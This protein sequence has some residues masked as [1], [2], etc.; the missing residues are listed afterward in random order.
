VGG[1]FYAVFYPAVFI[2]RSTLLEA[3][4]AT[5]T[6]VA[7]LLLTRAPI[8]GAIAPRV[9]LVAGALLGVSAGIKIWG[10]VVVAAV[11]AWTWIAHGVGR[12]LLLLAGAGIGATMICLPF[13]AAAPGTMWRM[14]VVDQLGRPRSTVGLG[15]RLTD[16]VGLSPLHVG[17]LFLAAVLVV[18]A[19]GGV[20]ALRSRQGRLAVVVLLA[21]SALLVCTPPWFTHY[22][23]L[24]AAPAA[25]IVGAA[26]STLIGRATS[27]TARAL[28]ASIL[29]GLAVAAV[30]VLS[31]K[32]GRSFPAT[33]IAER[34]ARLGGCVTTDDPTTLIETNLLQ[35]NLQ[36]GCKLVVDLGGYSYDMYPR[37][38]VPRS[39]NGPWQRFAID[40]LRSGSAVIVVRFNTGFGF[41][42]HSARVVRKWP[43]L[44]RDGRFALRSPVRVDR[45][46]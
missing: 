22:A 8:G 40:Y 28:I 33:P 15:G 38:I 3:P 2:E 36:R 41:S 21:S 16:M 4:A 1:L 26:A 11:L 23:G 19:A 45:G 39:L 6:L 20:L 5:V 9:V 29:A 30:P 35:S 14:V 10:V 42:A 7:L 46:S 43:M 25:I 24:T 18:A 12:G 27:I 17:A 34:A 31:N 44:A 37:T 13:F 32:F